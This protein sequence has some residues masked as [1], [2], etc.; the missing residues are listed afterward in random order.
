MFVMHIGIRSNVWFFDSIGDQSEVCKYAD[1]LF[2]LNDEKKCR[3][4][5]TLYTSF[6][7]TCR[8]LRITFVI[9]CVS[10]FDFEPQ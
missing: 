1:G 2:V 7:N 3:P 8:T 9:A 5:I 10:R 4:Q 6:I